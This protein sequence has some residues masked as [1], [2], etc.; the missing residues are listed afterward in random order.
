MHWPLPD[1]VTKASQNKAFLW[2]IAV[3]GMKK[4]PVGA[5]GILHSSMTEMSEKGSIFCIL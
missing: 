4:P 1:T 5:A 3:L 2:K